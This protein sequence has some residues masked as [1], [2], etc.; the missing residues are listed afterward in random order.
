MPGAGQVNH[1]GNVSQAAHQSGQMRPTAHSDVH[2]HRTDFRIP[3]L[4]ANVINARIDC[5]YV[6]R[7]FRQDAF[8]AMHVHSQRRPEFAFGCARLACRDN[9]VR[10]FAP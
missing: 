5:G 10:R 8:A 7:D 2:N 9:F 6:C 4:N 1:C 3:F